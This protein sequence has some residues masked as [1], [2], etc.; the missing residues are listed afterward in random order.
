MALDGRQAN[1]SAARACA[2]S[3]QERKQW[4][5]QGGRLWK[6]R[7]RTWRLSSPSRAPLQADVSSIG[8]ASLGAF[9]W[10]APPSSETSCAMRRPKLFIATLATGALPP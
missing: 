2:S 3:P 1:P 9:R 4:D 8:T 7:S 5:L 6:W 10:E